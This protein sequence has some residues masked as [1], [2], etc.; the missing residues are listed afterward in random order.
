MPEGD[1]DHTMRSSA[2]ALCSLAAFCATLPFLLPNL[3]IL[4]RLMM[5]VSD[6]TTPLVVVGNDMSFLRAAALAAM[7]AALGMLLVCLLK[8]AY[9]RLTY[10]FACL[11][12]VLYVAG[13]A[14]VDFVIP[15]M[16]LASPLILLTGIAVGFGGAVLCMAWVVQVRTTSYRTVLRWLV[17]LARVAA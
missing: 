12:G 15:G 8:T 11:A 6:G 13:C 3:D 17:L 10:R 1:Q 4:H 9:G 14:I 7:F 5:P 16:Q 2:F